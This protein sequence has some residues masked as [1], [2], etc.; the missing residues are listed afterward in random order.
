MGNLVAYGAVCWLF[1]DTDD[2]ATAE[3]VSAVCLAV[4]C[5]PLTLVLGALL[6]YWPSITRV[7]AGLRARD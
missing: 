4:F 5:W 2:D 6:V 1:R 3:N 7:V